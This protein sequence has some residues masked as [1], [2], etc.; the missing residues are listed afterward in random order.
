PPEKLPGPPS[1]PPV[2]SVWPPPGS[3]PGHPAARIT[4]SR[5]A[6]V[7]MAHIARVS[8][9]RRSGAVTA[10]G[11]FSTRERPRPT[12]IALT[13]PRIGRR[14]APTFVRRLRRES[15]RARHSRAAEPAVP[16]RVL[17]QVL[18]V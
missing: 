14:R 6:L 2:V 16:V 1:P 3:L 13:M 15:H 18:L 8:S 7:P 12:V 5:I 10:S 17:R 9:K 4:A 11:E